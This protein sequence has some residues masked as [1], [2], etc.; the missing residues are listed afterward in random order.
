MR[1]DEKGSSLRLSLFSPSCWLVVGIDPE[2]KE[3]SQ[4]WFLSILV[5][6]G[7]HRKNKIATTWRDPLHTQA[8][9]Q[10]TQK[11]VDHDPAR[12]N[13]LDS[14]IP[15]WLQEFR[16]N[17]VDEEFLNT[18]TRTRVLLTNHLWSRREKW[19]RVSTV[20]VLTLRKTEMGD[21]PEDPHYNCTVQKTCWW[22]RTCCKNFDDFIT[23]DHNFF[24]EGWK[25]PLCSR[26]VRLGYS[27]DSY[28]CKRKNFSGNWKE[29][30][31]VLGADYEAKSHLNWKFIEIWQT[32]WRSLVESLYVNP[33]PF[34]NTRSETKGI[35]ERAVRRIKEG[36][37][38]YCCNQVW[39]KN[40]GWI[41]WNATAICGIFRTSWQTGKLHTKGDLKDP[42]HHLDHLLNIILFSTED[43]PRIHHQFGKKV[44]PVKF[45]GHVES[46][47]KTQCERGDSA[48]KM[49]KNG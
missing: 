29:L 38:L 23:A 18:E 34:R 3:S 33:S 47:Q 42:L 41:P 11:N 39:M 32:L 37:L 27:M 13:P 21:L 2:E 16:E 45:L 20:F 8:K 7:L 35:A 30:A 25:S 43:Q 48:P 44:L 26:G 31:K 17:L 36:R 49:V 46:T 6:Y 4:L 22:S 40:G 9:S 14:E 24:S 12:G 1:C 19:Y 15:E 28:P 5:T 10:T